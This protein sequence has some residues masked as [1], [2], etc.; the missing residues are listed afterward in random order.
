MP[1][2][3]VI[4][5]MTSIVFMNFHGPFKW[6]HWSCLLQLSFVLVSYLFPLFKSGNPFCQTICALIQLSMGPIRN[7]FF[8]F[9]SKA[10]L[11]LYRMNRLSYA[12]SNIERGKLST[13]EQSALKTVERSRVYI[14]FYE[15]TNWITFQ[16]TRQR[17]AFCGYLLEGC[18]HELLSLRQCG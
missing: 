18:L 12:K 1:W 6:Y 11:L 4:S 3:M 14:Y 16:L 17:S 2:L 15:K 7:R 13:T 10:C 8:P 5:I 9:P